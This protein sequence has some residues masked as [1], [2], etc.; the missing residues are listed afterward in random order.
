MRLLRPEELVTLGFS[1]SP[2]V[3]M[4]EA[5][6]GFLRCVRCRRVGKLV[7][8]AAHAAGVRHLAM[9]ALEP[10]FAAEANRTRALPDWPG[11]YL[12]HP[13]LRA[14]IA[15]ALDLGWTLIAYECN[16]A[17]RPSGLQPGTMEAT[18]WREE[19]QAENI[20]V[21]TERIGAGEPMLVWCGNSHLSKARLGGWRPMASILRKL[22]AAEPF[23]IDQN[24]TVE[25]E[26]GRTGP[27]HELARRERD[28][29]AALGGTA[30]L[31]AEDAPYQAPGTDAVVLSTENSLE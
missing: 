10:R 21:A 7:L 27:W 28:T 16:H 4:N 20:A 6:N 26:P 11:G 23:S 25:F 5:H 19:R 31:L 3:L 8:P 24:V 22:I 1:R 13:E 2:L 17:R 29:L 30:G 18:N 12:A 15:A 14:F 9:E